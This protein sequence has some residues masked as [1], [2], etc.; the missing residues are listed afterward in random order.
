MI[1]TIN[2]KHTN[3][4]PLIEH[5]ETY[6]QQSSHILYDQRNVIRVVDYE[7]INYVVKAFKIPNLINRF[8]YRYLRPSKAK[9]SYFYALKIGTELSPEPIAYIEQSSTLLFTKSYYISTY[10]EYDYTIHEV[11]VN[12]NLESRDQILRD[13]ANFTYQ[14]HQAEILHHDYSHGN[15]LIK[16]STKNETKYEFKIIDINRMEFTCLD[17]NTRLKNFARIN[18]DDNDMEIIITQYATNMRLPAETL[19]RDAKFYRDDFYQKRAFKHKL[20]RGKS[21]TID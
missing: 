12:K 16:M 13:F 11:L 4:K 3:I 17:L 1:Y 10:F 2:P 19:L 15:I 8:A 5:I 14:L 7:N 21:N 18:A 9:R 20:R 6:F